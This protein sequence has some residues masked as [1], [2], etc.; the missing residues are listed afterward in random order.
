MN[1]LQVVLNLECGGLEKLVIDLS[2]ELNSRGLRTSIACIDKKGELAKE[3]ED[4]GIKVFSLEKGPDFDLGISAR[5]FKILKK[6]KIDLVHTHN[7]GPLIYGGIA[8]KMAGIPC[9]NTRHG[10]AEKKVNRF[11]WNLNRKIVAVSED[12]KK[13]LLKHNKVDA[14]KVKVIY[15]GVSVN[16]KSNRSVNEFGDCTVIGNVA[17]LSEEKDHFT[18]LEAFAL[19]CKE[20][21]D[22]IL[23]IVGDGHLR[24]CLESKVRDLKLEEKVLFLGMR[25]DVQDLMKAFDVFTLSSTM[26]GISLTLLEAMAAGKAIVATNVGGNKEVVK[27][28][29]SGVL[30]PKSNAKELAK[31]IIKVLKDKELRDRMGKKGL[32][33]VKERFSLDR[34]TKEYM[35]LYEDVNHK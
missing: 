16:G 4:K 22:A 34:M 23:V 7:F 6:E 1:I 30:V 33:I 26:E 27:D 31:A 8:A 3:A 17:R 24:D 12:A 25:D 13:E 35:E 21:E 14:G 9:I 32:E 2:N 20:I 11:I 10:R 19:I 5:L 15:N 18:L 28:A 29:E